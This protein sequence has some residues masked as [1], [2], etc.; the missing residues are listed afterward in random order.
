MATGAIEAAAHK[1]AITQI[2]QDDCKFNIYV[3]KP[4]KQV[5]QKQLDDSFY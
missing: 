4:T 2:Q 3:I 5:K 1:M